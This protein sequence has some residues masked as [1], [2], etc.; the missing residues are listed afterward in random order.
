M[1]PSRQRDPALERID[2]RGPARDLFAWAIGLFTVHDTVA[3]RGDLD[4]ILKILYHKD[5]RNDR[6][7]SRPST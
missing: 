5:L 4:S 2:I 7:A 3:L 6:T 1:E